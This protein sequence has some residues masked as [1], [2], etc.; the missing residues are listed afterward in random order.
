MLFVFGWL[1]YRTVVY[2]LVDR[3]LF[4]SLLTTFG[5]SILLQQLMNQVFGADIHNANAELG[6]T[7]LLDGG[8]VLGEH[9]AGSARAGAA[10]V[11]APPPRWTC[12]RA[13]SQNARAARLMGVHTDRV[14]A[15]R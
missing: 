3:D 4:V 6:V 10:A 2:R 14:Y 9:Q 15:L 1:L 13:T 12:I 7:F 8:V 5:L 11:S